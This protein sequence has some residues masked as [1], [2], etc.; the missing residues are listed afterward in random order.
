MDKTFEKMV[1]VYLMRKG[2]EVDTIDSVNTIIPCDTMAV[3]QPILLPVVVLVN[4]LPKCHVIRI[5]KLV[6]SLFDFYVF[7]LEQTNSKK[8]ARA[9]VIRI[10]LIN[11]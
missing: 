3:N 10:K 7:P 2:Y 8:Y 9:C 5:I 11:T 1:R 4:E 6:S